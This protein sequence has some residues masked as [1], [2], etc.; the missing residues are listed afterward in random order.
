MFFQHEYVTAG[1]HSPRM[2]GKSTAAFHPSPW[3]T[4]GTQEPFPWHNRTLRADL[5]SSGM[6]ECKWHWQHKDVQEM[7]QNLTG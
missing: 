6:G 1:T 4:R 3:L 2:S 7:A 5:L